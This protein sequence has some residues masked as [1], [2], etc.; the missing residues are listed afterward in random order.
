MDCHSHDI[1][2]VACGDYDR[3]ASR[4]STSQRQASRGRRDSPK[5]TPRHHQAEPNEARHSTDRSCNHILASID[6]VTCTCHCAGNN[7]GGTIAESLR[8]SLYLLLELIV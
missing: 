1:R 2:F 5:I 3:D 6:A 8:Q 4:M 7:I